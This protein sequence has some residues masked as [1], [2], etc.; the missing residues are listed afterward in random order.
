LGRET[1]SQKQ[2]EGGEMGTGLWRSNMGRGTTF[3]MQI[4]KITNKNY[5]IHIFLKK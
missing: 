4:N 1:P 2:G 5:K 3:E